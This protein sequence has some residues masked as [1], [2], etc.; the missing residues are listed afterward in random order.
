[1]DPSLQEWDDYEFQVRL[2]CLT[3]SVLKWQIVWGGCLEEQ[4]ERKD[5]SK[6]K[7]WQQLNISNFWNSCW[8]NWNTGDPGS[9]EG[10]HLRLVYVKLR[11]AHTIAEDG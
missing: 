1:M 9:T 2:E 8:Q 4:K 5:S 3:D 11:A 10:K 7:E 6:K